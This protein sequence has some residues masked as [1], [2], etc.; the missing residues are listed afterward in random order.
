MDDDPVNEE[1]AAPVEDRS[2]YILRLAFHYLV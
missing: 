2:A 1:D